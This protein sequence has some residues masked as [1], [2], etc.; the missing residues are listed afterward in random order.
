METTQK[1]TAKKQDAERKASKKLPINVL[2]DVGDQLHDATTTF[3][4]ASADAKDDDGRILDAKR[5]MFVT[6]GNKDELV[7]M[8]VNVFNDN[9][10]IGKIILEAFVRSGIEKICDKSENDENDND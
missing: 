8:F 3:L 1:E 4:L 5:L 9:P 2:V 6:H 10:Q 7:S